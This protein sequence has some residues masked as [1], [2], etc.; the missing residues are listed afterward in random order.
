MHNTRL[1][2]SI[3]AGTLLA[4]L[5]TTSMGQAQTEPSKGAT[6]K[7]AV[8]KIDDQKAVLATVE[9]IHQFVARARIGGT[10]TQ[11][12]IKEG[13]V[14]R[15]GDEVGLIVDQKL[16]LQLKA[17]DERIQSQEAQR[18]QAQIDFERISE[19]I[20]RGAGT[21]AQL[22]QTRTMLEVQERGLN[23]L[24]NDKAVLMQQVNEGK[25]ISP[26]S[27]RVLKVPAVEGS[28]V[29][30]GESIATLA[31]EHYILRLQLPE[32]HARSLRTG[33][34]VVINDRNPDDEAS[35]IKRQ[36]KVMIVYPEIQGGRVIADIQVP[37]LGSYFVG[38]RT[39]VFLSTGRREAILVPQKAVT[40]KAGLHYV[41][42][43]S[44]A[45]VVVQ[46]GERMDDKVEVL[47]G[48]TPG[49]VI[50]VSQP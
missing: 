37:D 33:D 24:R 7:I 31:E 21:Q 16:A 30:P 44:G 20:R 49:D 14:V 12:T 48:L 27:G 10:I 42:L 17:L 43:A 32:R 1:T 15:A 5:L 25:I 40:V 29:M 39:M 22:D 4:G 2:R 34:T 3:F 19:L 28:V 45:E 8:V 38:E 9:P 46:P 11:L 36:G 18:N 47:T 13:D 35:I 41:T 6:L 23:A 50:K 26:A